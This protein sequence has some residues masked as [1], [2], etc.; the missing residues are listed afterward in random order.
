MFVIKQI[1][2]FERNSVTLQ[3]LNVVR[4]A[5]NLQQDALVISDALIRQ[6]FPRRFEVDRVAF[7]TDAAI[8][9]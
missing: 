8:S 7:Q 9:E 5:A 2:F 1:L 6:I 4:H 3:E